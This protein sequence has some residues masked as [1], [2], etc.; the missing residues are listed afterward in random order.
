MTNQNR[1][2][3]N[4][5]H[6]PGGWRLSDILR[7]F[8][9]TW[10]LMRDP[11]VSLLLKLAL[12]FFALFYWISPLDLMIGPFDDT[13]ILILAVR[14]FVQ[15]APREA[16]ERA[17]ARMGRLRQRTPSDQ[18]DRDVWNIWNDESENSSDSNTIAGQ[19][20]VVDDKD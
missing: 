7:D 16:V 3:N 18:P 5:Q 20:R 12:T 9:I 6:I 17:L 11:R 10:Q 14:F 4:S 8:A 15:L 1:S 19:W 2:T 13:A